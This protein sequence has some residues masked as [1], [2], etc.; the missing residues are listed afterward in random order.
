MR[1][2]ILLFVL[3]PAFAFATFAGT[4]TSG[5]TLRVAILFFVLPLTFAFA[6]FAGTTT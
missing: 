3:P 1:V 4:T 5:G 6:T 2:A